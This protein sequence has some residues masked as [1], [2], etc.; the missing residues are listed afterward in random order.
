MRNFYRSLGALAVCKCGIKALDFRHIFEYFAL[1][2]IRQRTLES[3]SL[4]IQWAPGVAKERAASSLTPRSRGS[5]ASSAE[6]LGDQDAMTSV[7]KLLRMK[8]VEKMFLIGPHDSEDSGCNPR[9][10]HDAME[11]I[12]ADLAGHAMKVEARPLDVKEADRR[13]AEQFPSVTKTYITN[14]YR[15][16][17]LPENFQNLE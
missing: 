11:S 5:K 12:A 4:M 16:L 10:F 14:L 13:T 9:K 17:K 3:V 15:D 6:M 7:L 8:S 1:E 2:T